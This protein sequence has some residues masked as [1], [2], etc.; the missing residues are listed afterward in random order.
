MVE[1]SGRQWRTDGIGPKE[2]E[3]LV[4]LNHEVVP[5]GLQLKSGAL[6]LRGTGRSPS[7]RAFALLVPFLSHS[8]LNHTQP[9]RRT[10]EGL[11]KTARA[12]YEARSHVSTSASQS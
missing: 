3:R 11:F 7:L 5:G 1:S 6:R 4:P 10:M 12:E 2:G 8:T 9:H